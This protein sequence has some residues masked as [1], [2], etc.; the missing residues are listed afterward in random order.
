MNE[1]VVNLAVRWQS[2]IQSFIDK[3][4]HY[5]R[6]PMR[7]ACWLFWWCTY[8]C[9]RW[10][11]ETGSIMLDLEGTWNFVKELDDCWWDLRDFIRDFQ[12]TETLMSSFSYWEIIVREHFS[13]FSTTHPLNSD[14]NLF[15]KK[16]HFIQWEFVIFIFILN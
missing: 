3:C 12:G 6:L 13:H 16:I 11:R 4:Y 9:N 15:S 7:M 1:H 2:V 5:W 10:L 8:K 14:D